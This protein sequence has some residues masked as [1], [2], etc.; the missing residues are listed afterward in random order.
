MRRS[1]DLPVAAAHHARR[2]PPASTHGRPSR[3]STSCSARARRTGRCAPTSTERLA[4]DLD[5]RALAACSTATSTPPGRR[6]SSAL[7][8]QRLDIEL[9]EPVTARR[10]LELDVVA[11]GRHS[12]PTRASS[13]P[14]DG[15]AAGRPSTS[16]PSPATGPPART[17][18][19]G[20]P[21]GARLQRPPTGG[22]T[23]AAVDETVTTD[24]YT[25]RPVALPVGIAE[26]DL[27]GV[28]RRPSADDV[29]TGCRDDLVELDGRPLPVRVTGDRRP[30]GPRLAARGRCD[31]ERGAA[32]RRVDLRT[33]PG[34]EHG[35]G[36]RPPGPASSRR[37]GARRRR[38]P[39][40]RDRHRRSTQAAAR[41]DVTGAVATDGEPFWLRLDESM[42]EGWE[43][44]V[45]GRHRRGARARS[46]RFAA[47]WL[48]RPD[49]PG[50][51]AGHRSLGTP[52]RRRHRPAACRPPACCVCLAAPARRAGRSRRDRAPRA[53]G[54]AVARARPAWWCVALGDRRSPALL[55]DP[56]RALPWRRGPRAAP[57]GG[58]GSGGLHRRARGRGRRRPAWSCSS[59]GHGYRPTFDWPT[60]FPWVHQAARCSAWSSCSADLAAR[61]ALTPQAG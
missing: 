3:C 18:R 60:R 23:I 4:G 29:D 8:G 20:A 12:V 46:T 40:R 53:V 5:A 17:V 31:G 16:R 32:R 44:D 49:G 54:A 50:T 15:G 21:P 51:L 37:V 57:G 13:S 22:S 35:P 19:V 42:N 36:D 27:P 59:A 56:G 24:W 33:A 61:R 6:R 2:A 11:D 38:S 34:R 48:V 39:R 7:V 41:A 10:S 47:G 52:A 1:F 30:T 26:V 43:L 25:P 14:A 28:P 55:I 9:D 58:H 45:D